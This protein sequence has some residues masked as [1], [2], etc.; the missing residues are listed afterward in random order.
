MLDSMFKA[1]LYDGHQKSLRKQQE[2]SF[3]CRGLSSEWLAVCSRG[4]LPIREDLVTKGVPEQ[5]SGWGQSS[6]QQGFSTAE[7]T[8]QVQGQ[9]GI[10]GDGGAEAADGSV[11][12]LP[13]RSP[14]A[15]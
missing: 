8:L 11:L 7:G 10:A 5:A 6:Y 1:P 4:G 13:P 3:L 14:Q 12:S 15:G 9:S 2:R